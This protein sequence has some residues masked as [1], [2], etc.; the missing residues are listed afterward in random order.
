ML[1]LLLNATPFIGFTAPQRTRWHELATY[2]FEDYKAEFGRLRQKRDMEAKASKHASKR[3]HACARARGL[4]PRCPAGAPPRMGAN[5]AAMRASSPKSKPAAASPGSAA[6][7]SSPHAR[8]ARD[9]RFR[10]RAPASAA[11][12]PQRRRRMEM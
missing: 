12:Q 10:R 9:I 2:S 6:S 8:Y 7:W 1:A 11:V 3:V 4:W 5:S